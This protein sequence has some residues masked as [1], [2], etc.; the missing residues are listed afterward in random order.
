MRDLNKEFL[1]KFDKNLSNFIKR[2]R[3]IR[4]E[5]KTINDAEKNL[6]EYLSPWRKK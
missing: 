3:G 2:W 4:L 5:E 1:E 6:R